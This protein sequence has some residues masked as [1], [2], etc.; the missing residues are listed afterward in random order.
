[1]AGISLTSLYNRS[2]VLPLFRFEC[3][4]PDIITVEGARLQPPDITY[5]QKF[6]L[7]SQSITTE[8]ETWAAWQRNFPT[9]STVEDVSLTFV[10]DNELTVTEYLRQW[11]RV[12][13]DE[14]GDFGQ[15]GGDDGYWK[16]IIF[17]PLDTAGKR[18]R[19]YTVTDTYPIIVSPYEYDGESSTYLLVTATFKCFQIKSETV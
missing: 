7:P 1:M 18:I 17:Y 10:E 3:N 9:G 2:D 14:N 4:L 13:H 12:V 8:D 6:S 11:R 16:R 15:P 19:K 5:V